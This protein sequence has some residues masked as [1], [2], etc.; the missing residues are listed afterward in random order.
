MTRILFLAGLVAAVAS[1]L[2]IGS[3]PAVGYAMVRRDQQGD[4]YNAGADNNQASVAKSGS[5]NYGGYDSSESIDESSANGTEESYQEGS[6]EENSNNGNSDQGSAATNTYGNGAD[7]A[8]VNYPA[9]AA[10]PTQGVYQ[11]TEAP[12]YIS[13]GSTT[14]SGR[15][16]L[17]LGFGA[18]ALAL[19]LS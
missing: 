1:G 7:G 19:G 16:A 9:G 12:V 6:A 13:E 2:Q 5:A 15:V 18:V 14:S 4:S 11:N 8:N 17:A 3:A 10:S